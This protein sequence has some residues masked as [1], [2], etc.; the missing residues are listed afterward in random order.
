[1]IIDIFNNDLEVKIEIVVCLIKICICDF[2]VEIMEKFFLWL[3]F[4]KVVVWI[5][6]YKINLYELKN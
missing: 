2:V 1:M 4:K 6:C 3:C 5:F